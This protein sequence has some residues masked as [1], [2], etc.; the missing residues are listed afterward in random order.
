MPAVRVIV[1]QAEHENLRFSALVLGVV[2][3]VPFSHRIKAAE[4]KGLTAQK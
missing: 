2:R 1:R 3:S 4:P